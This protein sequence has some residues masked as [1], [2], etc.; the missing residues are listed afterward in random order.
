MDEKRR[1]K[2]KSMDDGFWDCSVCTYRNTPEA[3]KCEMCDVRKGTSTR[4]PR[5]NP[6]LVAQ[7][8]AQQFPAPPKKEKSAHKEKDHSDLKDPNISLK[9]NSPNDISPKVDVKDG[10]DMKEPKSEKSTPPS[11]SNTPRTTR[12]PCKLTQ[13]KNI[14]RSSARSMEVTVGDVTVIIT[15]YKPKKDKNSS[16]NPDQDINQAAG[17]ATSTPANGGRVQPNSNSN[18]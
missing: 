16:I 7:Q 1:S 9:D 10:K 11:T 2:R 4:K 5:L 8:V 15:D 17:T 13:L 14:D 12:R 3:F 6:Q 18:S